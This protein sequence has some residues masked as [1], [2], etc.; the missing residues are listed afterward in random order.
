MS[1]IDFSQSL[2]ASGSKPQ[3][4][5]DQIPIIARF[6]VSDRARQTLNLVRLYSCKTRRLL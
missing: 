1:K 4:A 5:A 2:L 6:A 3:T